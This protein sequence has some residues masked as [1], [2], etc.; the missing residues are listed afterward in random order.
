MGELTQ[1]FTALEESKEQALS[2]QERIME[3]QRSLLDPDSASSSEELLQLLAQD[4]L[5][6]HQAL[7]RMER[8][9]EQAE[10]ILSRAILATKGRE[11]IDELQQRRDRLNRERMEL[12]EL[13]N[14][15][16][17][18]DRETEMASKR[19]GTA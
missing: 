16:V 17:T 1:K 8:Q 14:C 2:L 10:K 19:N 11:E 5:D 9:I 3:Q 12:K 13:Q 4:S 7:L 18:L 6:G 15:L